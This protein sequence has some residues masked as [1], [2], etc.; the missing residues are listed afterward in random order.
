MHNANNSLQVKWWA[1]LR[2][3]LRVFDLFSGE[4]AVLAAEKH[5]DVMAQ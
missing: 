5:G 3:F 2:S 1:L 4:S